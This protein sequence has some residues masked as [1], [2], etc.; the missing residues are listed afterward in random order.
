M[1]CNDRDNLNEDDKTSISAESRTESEEKNSSNLLNKALLIGIIHC[2]YQ[3][4]IVFLFL[5]FCT[6]ST[7]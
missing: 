3:V 2:Y 1:V 5:R 6:V 4:V 7:G